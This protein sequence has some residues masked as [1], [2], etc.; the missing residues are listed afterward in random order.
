MNI[1]ILQNELMWYRKG[2]NNKG[3]W[4]ILKTIIFYHKYKRSN[5]YEVPVYIENVDSVV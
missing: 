4:I 3:K 5:L 1:S 2:K